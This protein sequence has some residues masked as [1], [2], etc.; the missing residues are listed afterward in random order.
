L[1]PDNAQDAESLLATRAEWL[2]NKRPE[3]AEANGVTFRRW[4]TCGQIKMIA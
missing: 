1:F 4:V 3:C 2:Q